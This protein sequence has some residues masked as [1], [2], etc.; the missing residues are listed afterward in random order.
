MGFTI[1]IEN[2]I[3]GLIQ[4]NKAQNWCIL[5]TFYDPVLENIWKNEF[6]RANAQIN[7]R[8]NSFY[9]ALLRSWLAVGQFR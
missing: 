3:L 4:E 2:K 9:S 1:G 5:Q 7:C 8:Q 6:S